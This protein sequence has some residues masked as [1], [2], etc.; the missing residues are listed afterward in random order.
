MWGRS[1]KIEVR[2][3]E[4]EY[5]ALAIGS[6]AWTVA[7]GLKVDAE[8]GLVIA[9]SGFLSAALLKPRIT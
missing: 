5:K 8:I 9:H 1:E 4:L 2:S 6:C 7:V 3:L